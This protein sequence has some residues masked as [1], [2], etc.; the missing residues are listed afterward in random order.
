MKIYLDVCCLNR[1]FDDQTQDRIRLETEAVILVLEHVEEGDWEL[2]GSDV[3]RF[4]IGQIKDSTRRRRV[5]TLFYTVKRNIR[6]DESIVSRARELERLGISGFDSLHLACAEK[7]GADILLTTDDRLIRLAA[8]S[9]K[10][11][12][13]SVR[14]P[15]EWLREEKK[16]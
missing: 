12:G 7:A 5:E 4:E 10:V 9:A 13:V 15:V 3:M 11:I 16:S 6:L 1:P 2:V 8:R 14:N